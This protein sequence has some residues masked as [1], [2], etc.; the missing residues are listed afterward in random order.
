MRLWGRRDLRQLCR[1][2]E[3]GRRTR[4]H[5]GMDA[6]RSRLPEKPVNIGFTAQKA[7]KQGDGP[8]ARGMQ[9]PNKGI[10]TWRQ[11][12][13]PL[14]RRQLLLTRAMEPGGSQKNLSAEG[15]YKPHIQKRPVK[16]GRFQQLRYSASTKHHNGFTRHTDQ[17]LFLKGLQYAPR[18]LAGTTNDATDFLTG[19]FDLHAVWVCHSV[20]LFAKIQ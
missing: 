16:T 12:K 9:S 13:A 1:Q 4:L 2:S 3:A 5:T 10:G 18:H 14:C 19:N 15:S 20:W 8:P 6:R 17:P 7:R 11:P